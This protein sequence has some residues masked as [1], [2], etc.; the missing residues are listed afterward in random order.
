MGNK[1]DILGINDR[2]GNSLEMLKNVNSSAWISSSYM[3]FWSVVV[4]SVG[5]LFSTIYDSVSWIPILLQ[6]A[7]SFMNGESTSPTQSVFYW[8]GILVKGIII[9]GYVFYFIGI[10]DFAK[11]Q[12]FPNTVRDVYKVR[13]AVILLLITS[14]VNFLFSFLRSIPLLGLLFGLIMFILF[15]VGYIKMRNAYAGLMNSEDFN[16][17]AKLGAGNLRFAANCRIKLQ[18]LPLIALVVMFIL[19]MA[20]GGIGSLYQ[21]LILI[22]VIGVIFAIIILYWAICAYLFPMIGWYRIKSGGLTN[23][24][25]SSVESDG[26]LTSENHMRD[27]QEQSK[28]EDST[29]NAERGDEET[30]TEESYAQAS[31][32][33]RKGA[34]L[35][36]SQVKEAISKAKNW[37]NSNQ[38][39]VSYF[40]GAALAAIIAAIVLPKFMAE[41][42]SEALGVKIPKW[43]KYLLI[44]QDNYL[45]YKSPD[46][47]SAHLMRCIY[48]TEMEMDGIIGYKWS[49][50]KWREEYESE[51][52]E[53]IDVIAIKNWDIYPIEAENGIWFKIN[54]ADYQD[55]NTGKYG[56]IKKE[57]GLV[58]EP[59]PFTHDYLNTITTENNFIEFDYFDEE[60]YETA[61][62]KDIN[63]LS[64]KDFSLN[65]KNP[66]CLH[67]RIDDT[68]GEREYVLELGFL[69]NNKYLIFPEQNEIHS[70]VLVYEQNADDKYVDFAKTYLGQDI[71]TSINEVKHN[72]AKYQNVYMY[73]G[74][75]GIR[76]FTDIK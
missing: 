33:N 76:M 44:D 4:I 32:A 43:E 29:F 56:Y 22:E 54:L 30:K 66:I 59:L 70:N 38:K 40:A 72:K 21:S 67:A 69:V 3:V 65:E 35:T 23:I 5:G 14:I 55:E 47:N 8:I 26:V 74:E 10:T 48:E 31:V 75:N 45:I 20:M 34:T 17:L 1:D 49:D 61:G 60:R 12:Q 57:S 52:Y 18:L 71:M 27:Y 7:L 64:F 58:K 2:E 51:E 24:M 42:P 39:R 9:A 6:S 63:G 68:R 50:S 53:T 36:S 46:E 62:C 16:D 25:I 73:F 13:S 15:L 28:N 41:T 11:A 37:I 19:V